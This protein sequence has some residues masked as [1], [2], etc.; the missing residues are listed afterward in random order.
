MDFST[1]VLGP[2]MEAFSL[3]VTITPLKSKPMAAPYQARGVWT[4]TDVDIVTEDGGTFSNRTLKFGI[5]LLEFTV[6]PKQG[7]LITTAVSGLPLAYWQGAIDPSGNIDLLVDDF[8]PDGQGGA[9]L[10]VKRVT[11]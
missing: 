5:R 1:L 7:D 6:A 8:R 10:I 11:T 4:I 3:P 2:A 9:T